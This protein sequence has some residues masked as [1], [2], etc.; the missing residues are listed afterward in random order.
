MSYKTPASLLAHASRAAYVGNARIASIIFALDFIFS[1]LL[2]P[3][4]IATGG[5]PYN[6]IYSVRVGRAN[7]LY[8]AYASFMAAANLTDKH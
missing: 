7:T 1:T 8:I 3:L 4:I 2:I 6:A 5:I